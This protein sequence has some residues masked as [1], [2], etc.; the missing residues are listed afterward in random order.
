MTEIKLPGRA[1]DNNRIEAVVDLQITM[2]LNKIGSGFVQLSP[3]CQGNS[4]FRQSVAAGLTGFYFHKYHPI[5]NSGDNI[6]FTSIGAKIS[7]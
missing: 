4:L 1:V 6:N 7:R 2:L 3:L 5:S